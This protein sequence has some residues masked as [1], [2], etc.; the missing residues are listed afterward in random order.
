[1]TSPNAP[2]HLAPVRRNVLAAHPLVS[3]FLIAFAFSWLMFL[4][5]PL[6]YF[7]VLDLEP[8]LVGFEREHPRVGCCRIPGVQPV[9]G[10]RRG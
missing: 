6:T 4:L 1:M 5:G 10:R 8:Q 9:R 3:F 2:T 7:G